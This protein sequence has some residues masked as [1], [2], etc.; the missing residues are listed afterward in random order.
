ML[1]DQACVSEVAVVMLKKSQ[2]SAPTQRKE[3]HAIS[4]Y[5]ALGSFLA[6]D[7]IWLWKDTFTYFFV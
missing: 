7:M 4:V 5:L 6:Q 3:I 1:P 2:L